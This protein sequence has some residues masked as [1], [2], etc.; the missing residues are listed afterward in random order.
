[1][2]LSIHGYRCLQGET[3]HC[4]SHSC[5]EVFRFEVFRSYGMCFQL[6]KP[7]I[8]ERKAQK[9]PDLHPPSPSISSL[10]SAHRRTLPADSG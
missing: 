1:M 8:K 5:G 4:H 7:W 2:R 9:T 10:L 3:A 6:L